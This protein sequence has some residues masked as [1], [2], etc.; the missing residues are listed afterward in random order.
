MAPWLLLLCGIII[1]SVRS[2]EHLYVQGPC[3]L[4]T[5]RGR[6]LLVASRGVY[7]HWRIFNVQCVIW[8]NCMKA[9]L[10]PWM[11]APMPLVQ[12]PYLLDLG[13]GPGTAVEISRASDFPMHRCV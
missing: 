9:P 13:E 5:L 4:G 1:L 2:C 12:V 6:A 11:H 7:A 10:H 8:H 3:L